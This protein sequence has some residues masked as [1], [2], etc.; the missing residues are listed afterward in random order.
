[1]A[2]RQ[3]LRTASLHER[4]GPRRA[5]SRDVC[6]RD[7]HP[8]CRSRIGDVDARVALL[9]PSSRLGWR[10]DLIRRGSP[11][12]HC[13]AWIRPRLPALSVSSLGGLPPIIGTSTC[14]FFPFCFYILIEITSYSFWPKVI[15]PVRDLQKVLALYIVPQPIKLVDGGMLILFCEPSHKKK[16]N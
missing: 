1:M 14:G 16:H 6:F 11:H 8:I 13:A 5:R 2:P 10:G 7:A 3:L 9:L 4:D 12:F 15:A